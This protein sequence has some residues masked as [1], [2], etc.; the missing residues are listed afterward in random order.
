MYRSTLDWPP[1]EEPAFQLPAARM[2]RSDTPMLWAAVA[3][4]YENPS[5]ATMLCVVSAIFIHAFMRDCGH[6]AVAGGSFS[7][8]V[9]HCHL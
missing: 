2:E 6:P 8:G 3:L 4:E 9:A 7:K 5:G 1:A